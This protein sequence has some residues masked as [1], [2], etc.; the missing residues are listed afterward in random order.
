MTQEER[1]LTQEEIGLIARIKAKG[2]ELLALQGEVAE[3]IVQRKEECLRT[4]D[5]RH[6][7][8]FDVVWHARKDLQ[9]IEEAEAYRW[10]AIAKTDI[11]TGIMAL[12]RAVEKPTD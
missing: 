7:I 10:A 1:E 6:N 8:K 2:A 9:L 12:V 3:A 4:E 5:N 11:Q